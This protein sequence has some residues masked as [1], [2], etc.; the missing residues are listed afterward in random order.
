M[1]PR[2]RAILEARWQVAGKPVEGWLWAAGTAS[3]HIEPSTVKKQ[4]KRALKDSK[5]RR[6]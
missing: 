4:H 6:S 5:V 1:S 3:G 2:V